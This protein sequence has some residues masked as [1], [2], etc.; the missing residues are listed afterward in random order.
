MEAIHPLARK[1]AGGKKR[2]TQE[3]ARRCCSSRGS[4]PPT[5][6]P[7]PARPSPTTHRTGVP[8]ARK[9]GG[10]T[11][12]ENVGSSSLSFTPCRGLREH[13]VHFFTPSSQHKN[14]FF[15][16]PLIFF[17]FI[18]DTLIRSHDFLILEEAEKSSPAPWMKSRRVTGWRSSLRSALFKAV[19]PFLLSLHV[20]YVLVLIRQA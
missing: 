19:S 4:S 15:F 17:L 3:K 14:I 7:K 8:S 18:F 1:R 16:V 20:C 13:L 6:P 5:C 2:S 12:N 11:P 10:S 9:H